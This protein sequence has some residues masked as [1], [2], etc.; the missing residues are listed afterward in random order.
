MRPLFSINKLFNLLSNITHL[1]LQNKIS[2][3]MYI[4]TLFKI[5]HFLYFF[6]SLKPSSHYIWA[7]YN[8]AQN[9]MYNLC[10]WLLSTIKRHFSFF[11]FLSARSVS[12]CLDIWQQWTSNFSPENKIN[13]HPDRQGGSKRTRTRLYDYTRMNRPSRLDGSDTAR[14]RGSNPGQFLA[15]ISTSSPVG[16]HAWLSYGIWR[17]RV[18]QL[19]K[20]PPHIISSN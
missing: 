4:F 15:R 9:Q 11:F 19:P 5:F 17:V 2:N 10:S 14:C 6:S 8:R 20:R 7:P 13:R 18:Y 3:T 16:T 12:S 1:I